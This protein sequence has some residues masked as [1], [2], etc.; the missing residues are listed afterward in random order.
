[1]ESLLNQGVNPNGFYG[2]LFPLGVAAAGYDSVNAIN[3]IDLLIKKGA[4]PNLKNDYGKTALMA[5]ISSNW[6]WNQMV[7]QTLLNKGA[8]LDQKDNDGDS[9]LMLSIENSKALDFLIQSGANVNIQANDG[10]TALMRAIW[11]I[12]KEDSSFQAAFDI[13]L[14]SKPNLELEVQPP[15]SYYDDGVRTALDLTV[16]WSTSTIVSKLLKAGA[17]TEGSHRSALIAAAKADNKYEAADLLIKAGAKI[18]SQDQYGN[19]PLIYGVRENRGDSV[20]NL[21]LASGAS[22]DI[23]NN[24]GDT[25]LLLAAQEG[26]TNYKILKLLK[27]GANP[28][29]QGKNDET[30]MMQISKY[31]A[32]NSTLK[33]WSEFVNA[34]ANLNLQDINGKTILM[35]MVDHYPSAELFIK[36]GANVNLRNHE[37]KTA[38]GLARKESVRK[39][40][41]A[42]GGIE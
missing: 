22:L 4:D 25:A 42:A 33:I 26:S 19:T 35:M 3:A 36:A 2:N 6:Y 10:Y 37:G 14:N 32:G 21:I 20:F 15:L 30:A 17:K 28:N 9:A 11:Q 40:L 1:M 18:N 23:Q 5:S 24:N 34:G 38:L 39:V 27:A 12:N 29:I 16:R 31:G 8:Q 7:T 13:I 41:I